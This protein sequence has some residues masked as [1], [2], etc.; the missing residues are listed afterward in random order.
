[1][2]IKLLKFNVKL[3]QIK[4][5][6]RKK[7]VFYLFQGKKMKKNQNNLKTQKQQNKL[8]K[9][10]NNLKVQKYKNKLIKNYRKKK[11]RN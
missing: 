5:N 6:Y 2:V 1:M 8:M 4:K 9:N 10:Q 3:K 11:K 7:Q